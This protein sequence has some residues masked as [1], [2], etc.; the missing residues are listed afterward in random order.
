VL[1]GF[2]SAGRF[3]WLD[4]AV[5][6]EQDPPYANKR[7]HVAADLVNLVDAVANA[8]ETD[9]RVIVPPAGQLLPPVAAPLAR[10]FAALFA[11]AYACIHPASGTP[12]RQ[13]PTRHFAALIDLLVGRSGVQVALLGG[14]DERAIADAVLAQVRHRDGVHDLVG[15]SRLAEVPAIIAGSR[16]FVGNN[17]G[18]QHIAAG[19]GVPTVGVHSGVVA[20][21]EWGPLGPAAVALRRD[22]SC[23]PCYRGKLGDCHRAL[24]CVEDLPPAWVHAV[25]ERL[26]LL[27]GTAPAARTPPELRP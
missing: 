23:A 25:C 17:S 18:P 1:A 10:E 11:G 19:L 15:R 3:P 22:M 12:M 26:L 4:V 5:E 13:W 7:N 6:W 2:D 21:E 14:P 9:R 16:L 20:S 8:F 24:A 27:R